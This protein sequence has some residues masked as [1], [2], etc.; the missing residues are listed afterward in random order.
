MERRGAEEG[1]SGEEVG[2]RK[3]SG[4]R[5]RQ[6]QRLICPT[7]ALSLCTIQNWVREV[8]EPPG[9][10]GCTRNGL[11]QR[12]TP[13][14]VVPTPLGATC[15]RTETTCLRRLVEPTSWRWLMQEPQLTLGAAARN[16]DW[17]S[18][19]GRHFAHA[20]RLLRPRGAK[21][22]RQTRS[23]AGSPLRLAVCVPSSCMYQ[24][25]QPLAASMGPVT[26]ASRGLSLRRHRQEHQN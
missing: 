17:D 19:R 26:N 11:H 13:A 20:L 10:R 18:L 6:P 2:G 22:G 5:G 15:G 14:G 16:G 23:R 25:R 3:R 21:G 12:A 9:G 1:M 24:Y 4:A 7:T 8:F